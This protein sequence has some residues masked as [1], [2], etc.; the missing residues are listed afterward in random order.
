[1][2]FKIFIFEPPRLQILTE[3]SFG[4][5]SPENVWNGIVEQ[6]HSHRVPHREPVGGF[7][8]ERTV[9]EGP[10]GVYP[11]F[12]GAVDETAVDPTGDSVYLSENLLIIII[13]F[14]FFFIKN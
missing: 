6:W 9:L 14:F 10:H 1:M 11:R 5:Q 2:R 8:E 4:T 3:K 13:N 7:T 12:A